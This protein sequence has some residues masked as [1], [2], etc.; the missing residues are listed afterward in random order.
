MAMQQN[1]DQQPTEPGVVYILENLS[2]PPNVIKIGKTCQDDWTNRIRQLNTAVP[3]PFT[4][5]KASRVNNI[6]S[7]ETFLHNT[8]NPAKRQWRG[9]FY[10]VESWRVAQILELFEIEDVTDQAPQPDQLEEQAINDAAAATE[11]R[12]GFNFEAAGIPPGSKLGFRGRPDIEAEVVDGATTINYQGEDYALSTLATKIKDKQYVVQG[13]LWWTYQ[14]ETLMQ[15]RN[16]IEA[17]G[18]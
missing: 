2:L 16:R 9:E 6:S 8:F 18:S 13:T 14:G 3:L 4:C 12:T 17:E 11:R 1:S 7:V 10:E 5:Y 15:R